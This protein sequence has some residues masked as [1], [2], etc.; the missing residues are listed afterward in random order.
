MRKKRLSNISKK[1][2][3]AEMIKSRILEREKILNEL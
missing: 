3:E 1:D 2:E